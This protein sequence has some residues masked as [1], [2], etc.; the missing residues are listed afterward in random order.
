MIDRV[1]GLDELVRDLDGL[2]RSYPAQ[3]AKVD[4]RSAE[5][6]LDEA[7]A[8]ARNAGGAWLAVLRLRAMRL[9][10][11]HAAAAVVLDGDRAAMALGAEYGALQWPQFKA[12][13]GHDERAGYALLPALRAKEQKIVAAYE[14]DFFKQAAP[15]FPD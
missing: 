15:A 4:A 10:K 1:E 14:A 5:V 12:Y 6:V 13:R 3:V 9:S 2:A 11:A 8:R 7:T